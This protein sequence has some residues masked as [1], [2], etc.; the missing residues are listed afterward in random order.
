[1]RRQKRGCTS[2]RAASKGSLRRRR[3]G[4]FMT[5]VAAAYDDWALFFSNDKLASAVK[6]LN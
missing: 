4:V 6:Q 3:R 2:Y 5:C 1:M